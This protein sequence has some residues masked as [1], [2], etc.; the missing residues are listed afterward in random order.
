MKIVKCPLWGRFARNSHEKRD[1][2]ALCEA[3]YRG[4]TVRERLA[5]VTVFRPC[6]GFA[7]RLA[8]LIG[9]PNR[10]I[11]NR[12]QAT[13]LPHVCLL[14]AVFILGVSAAAADR[15]PA[16]AKEIEP[17]TYSYVDANGDA[18]MYRQTPFGLTKW[19]PA[20]VPPP[21][22]KDQNPV[23]ATDLGDS[24][25][26]ERNTPFGHYVSTVKKTDL[27]ADQKALLSIAAA[28]GEK[29]SDGEK[30]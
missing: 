8:R 6:G 1:R 22:F 15:I 9:I 18:W 21:R 27:T 7:I 11:A 24:V 3:D 13:S 12:P 5:A 23:T 4:A 29:K 10:P 28:G 20:D 19:R 2:A 25:R 16:G 30:K 26:I 17:Y 14:L